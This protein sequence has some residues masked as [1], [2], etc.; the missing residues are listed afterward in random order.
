MNRSLGIGAVVLL[1]ATAWLGLSR[2]QPAVQPNS[3]VEQSSSPVPLQRKNDSSKNQK[4]GQ[5]LSEDAECS[6]IEDALQ[7]FFLIDGKQIEAPEYCWETSPQKHD[8]LPA[9]RKAAAANYMIALLPDPVHTHL[10]ITFDRFTE[11]IEHAGQLEDFTYD[12][13]WL[14]W[15]DSDSQYSH[16][17]D[18]LIAQRLN[19]TREKQPGVL[20]F[21]NTAKPGQESQNQA[22][23]PY[24]GALVILIVGETPTRGVNKPQFQN[25][26][27]WLKTLDPSF[28]QGSL[29]VL[30]PF[31]SGS[32][33][34]LQ[35]LLRDPNV[36]SPG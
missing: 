21:R 26:I 10:A 2:M 30:G 33:A 1:V 14:P 24:S 19:D 9:W 16:L 18:N 3:I 32:F 8:Q 11:S 6:G 15:S 22:S 5:A 29:R 12:S 20:L 25:A 27:A 31:A 13:S 17:A 28:S 23:D 34:S 36:W 35:Q 7:R 4:S